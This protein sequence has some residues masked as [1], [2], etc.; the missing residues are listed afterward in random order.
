MTQ[1]DWG[2]EAISHIL[3][4]QKGVPTMKIDASVVF[5]LLSKS[6]AIDYNKNSEASIEVSGAEPYSGSLDPH[7]MYIID[8]KE[9][10]TRVGY[11]EQCVF[12]YCSEAGIKEPPPGTLADNVA[13]ITAPCS[14]GELYGKI[15]SIMYALQV[16]DCRMK[17]ACIDA[18]NLHNLMEIARDVLDYSFSVIDRNMRNIAYSP[19]FFGKFK[20]FTADPEKVS[21]EVVSNLLSDEQG[22]S[23]IY[24]RDTF[25]YPRQ[26]CADKFICRNIFAGDQNIAR[27]QAILDVHEVT[28]GECRLF[29]HIYGYISKVFLSITDD[30]A[31]MRQNDR[32]HRCINSLLFGGKLATEEHASVFSLYNWTV[33]QTFTAI[34]VRLVNS[35]NYVLRGQYMCYLLEQMLPG[36]RAVYGDNHIA[37]IINHGVGEPEG[38]PDKLK[39]KLDLCLRDL[40]CKAGISDLFNDPSDV[41]DYYIQAS[42]AVYLGQ[43]RFPDRRYFLFSDVSLDYALDNVCGQLKAHH[44]LHKGLLR[45][46]EYDRKHDSSYCES[47][48]V[49]LS[50]QFNASAA[51]DKCYVHRSTFIRRLERISEISGMNLDDNDEILHILISFRLSLL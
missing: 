26:Q 13:Y 22:E 8:E 36:S 30:T 42:Q 39:L 1:A 9:Q 12:V 23:D 51:A 35:D 47:L 25:F 16:W 2:G 17:D 15:V 33:G 50:S 4:I 21:D 32:L 29:E 7:R 44:I 5:Y 45:L 46:R 10:V 3:A 19:D 49:Y 28:S 18:P 24:R 48:Y 6:I 40:Q 14:R 27:F 37:C 20:Y 31:V 34:V 38:L 11:Q 41:K 43:K